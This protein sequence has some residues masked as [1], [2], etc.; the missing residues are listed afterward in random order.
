MK[1]DRPILKRTG[2]PGCCKN[3]G[4]NAI[5]SQVNSAASSVTDAVAD[6]MVT[7]IENTPDVTQKIADKMRRNGTD[8]LQ[9]TSPVHRGAV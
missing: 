7:A 6:A 1:T 3:T 5:D 2:L 4:D 9:S 8:N